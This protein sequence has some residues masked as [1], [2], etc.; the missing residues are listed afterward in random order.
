MYG[1]NFDNYVVAVE[2]L[3]AVERCSHAVH[4]ITAGHWPISEQY[5]QMAKQNGLCL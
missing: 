4:K 3:V 5:T 1:E 2:N